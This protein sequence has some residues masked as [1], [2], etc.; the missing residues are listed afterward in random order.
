[1]NHV[2][3]E[4]VTLACRIGSVWSKRLDTNGLQQ[5]ALGGVESLWST[6]KHEYYYRHVFATKSEL[7]AAVDK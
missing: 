6:F 5:G 2:A 4:V 1:M 7:V 3:S